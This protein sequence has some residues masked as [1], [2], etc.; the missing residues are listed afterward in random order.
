ME[1]AK[2]LCTDGIARFSKN[3]GFGNRTIIVCFATLSRKSGSNAKLPFQAV[4]T[5]R[6]F[7]E[8]FYD[9]LKLV[10]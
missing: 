10:F 6:L 1:T 7:N 5:K 3:L 4:K 2:K 9:L 8:Y